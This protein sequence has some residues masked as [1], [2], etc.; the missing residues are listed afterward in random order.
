MLERAHD[1][2]LTLCQEADLV[3]VPTAV[4]A[5]KD[6]AELLKLPYLSVTLMPWAIP[7]HDPDR[8]LVRLMVKLRFLLPAI[9]LLALASCSWS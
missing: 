9:S 7:W 2:I 5:G 4:A 6:E 3:V 1:D 8:P